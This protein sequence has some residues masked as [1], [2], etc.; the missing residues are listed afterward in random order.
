MTLASASATPATLQTITQVLS[1]AATSNTPYLLGI[2]L[3]TPLTA[4]LGMQTFYRYYDSGTSQW[5]VTYSFRNFSAAV[6]SNVS[7][8]I[9]YYNI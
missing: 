2:E 5:K 8:N 3:T 4:P 7:W 1:N 6:Q 9:Y